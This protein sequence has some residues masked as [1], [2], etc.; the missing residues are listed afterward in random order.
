MEPALEQECRNAPS[1]S[2]FVA[3][4]KE[5]RVLSPVRN[6]LSTEELRPESEAK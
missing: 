6:S 3:S 4:G 2:F 5:V 1:S